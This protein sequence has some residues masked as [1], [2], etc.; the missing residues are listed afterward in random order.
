MGIQ[1]A[2]SLYSLRSLSKEEERS[3]A[4][5]S[6]KGRGSATSKTRSQFVIKP[7][8]NNAHI[9]Y[10]LIKYFLYQKMMEWGAYRFSS[11]FIPDVAT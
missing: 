1:G 9:I 10:L 8:F 7:C 11:L 2:T 6:S 3:G 5:I 4:K